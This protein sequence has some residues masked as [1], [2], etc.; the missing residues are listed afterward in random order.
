MVTIVPEPPYHT[1]EQAEKAFYAAFE[2][3]N[4]K[5]MRAVWSRSDDVLC[6]HPMGQ[7]IIGWPD[8]ERSWLT[9]FE[10]IG[11]ARF[12][13]SDLRV[14]DS[15]RVSVRY[16]HE[17]IHHGPGYTGLSTVYATNVYRLE[18]AGWQMVSHHASP[19][20]VVRE[21]DGERPVH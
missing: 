19:G 10:G 14:F 8:I 1:A 15:D 4:I 13:L 11:D 7:P 18:D 6:V 16:V 20:G 5:I 9:I 3:R 2:A 21:P 12:S 17:N